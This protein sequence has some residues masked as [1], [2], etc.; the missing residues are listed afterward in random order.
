M[1]RIEE[2]RAMLE[3]A[4][5]VVKAAQAKGDEDAELRALEKEDEL[6]VELGVE[7]EKSRKLAGRRL[8]R[9]G[10]VKAAGAYQVGWFDAAG[11]LSQIDTAR[12][13]ANGVLL[14]RDPAPDAR[15]A[16]EAKSRAAEGRE[17]DAEKAA[18]SAEATIDLIGACTLV[19][20]FERGDP[21]APAYRDFWEGPGRGLIHRA[22]LHVAQLGGLRQKDFQAA[23]R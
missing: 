20:A 4:D 8:E 16:F 23:P 18:A 2:L 17:T 3:A 19:P 13:P 14:F 6:R 22:F 9:D 1:N 11:G 7:Q 12:I 15:A 5:D 21:A 10:K